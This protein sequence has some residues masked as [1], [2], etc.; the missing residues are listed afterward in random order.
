MPMVES[1]HR[2][3]RDAFNVSKTNYKETHELFT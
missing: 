1:I 3:L 2:E